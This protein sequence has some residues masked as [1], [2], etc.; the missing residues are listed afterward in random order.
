M[1]NEPTFSTTRA[2]PNPGIDED[3]GKII[4]TPA[5]AYVHGPDS[6]R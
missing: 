1:S 3:Q 4:D 5:V 2:E 6:R